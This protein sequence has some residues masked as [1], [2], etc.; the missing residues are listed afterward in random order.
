MPAPQPIDLLIHGSAEVV[1]PLGQTALR[2][3]DLGNVSVVPDGAVAVDDGRV[4]EVGRSADLQDKYAARTT[5]DAQG[6]TVL[7]GLVDAHTHPVFMGTRE[8]EFEMRAAGKTFFE[9]LVAPGFSVSNGSRNKLLN[10]KSFCHLAENPHPSLSKEKQH[11]ILL[12]LPCSECRP[13]FRW[14]FKRCHG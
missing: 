14:L 9:I 8:A 13:R 6:G 10:L 4:L 5:L 1:T 7:P 11:E 12:P 2:G 3:A